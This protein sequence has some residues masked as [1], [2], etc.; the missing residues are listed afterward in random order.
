MKYSL[1]SLMIGITLFC[2]ALG[3]RIEYFRRRAVFHEHE[4][5]RI[6]AQVRTE[7]GLI[8][9]ESFPDTVPPL[10]C[11]Q[12]RAHFQLAYEYR[13]ATRMP[14]VTIKSESPPATLE[15]WD[16]RRWKLPAELTE[17]TP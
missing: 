16:Q 17:D 9:I 3:G 13:C 6:E 14:W 7:F 12:L 15:E 10:L 2:V 1:R 5:A 4:A 8:T 11:L